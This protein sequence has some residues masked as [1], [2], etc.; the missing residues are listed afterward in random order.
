MTRSHKHIQEAPASTWSISHNLGSYPVVDAYV[1]VNGSLIK[2]L[3]K[4]VTY[5][6]SNTCTLEFTQNYSGIAMVA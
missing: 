1:D 5:V 6:N 2:I 4:S 3:P